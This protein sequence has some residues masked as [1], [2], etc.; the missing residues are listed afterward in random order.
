MTLKV[1]HLFSNHKVTGPAEL[2]LDTSRFI[3]RGDEDHPE[4]S[5]EG[6]FLSSAHPSDPT[7]LDD[8]AKERNSRKVTVDGLRLGKHFN[9]FRAFLDSKKLTQELKRG[10]YDLLHCHLPND[11]MIA[12]M[13]RSRLPK[14]KRPPIVRTL[15][16][17]VTPKWNW[18]QRKTLIKNTDA[19]VCFS[20]KVRDELLQEEGM[21]QIEIFKLDPPIDTDRFNNLDPEP[22]RKGR[23]TYGIDTDTFTVGIVARMQ[24]HRRFEYVL[25]AVKLAA[26]KIP[27]F[28]FVIIGRGTNQETVA[29]QPVKEMGLSDVVIFSGYISG[30]SYVETLR[31]LDAKLFVVPGSD[32]TCRA[33]REALSAGIP[34]I[35]AD[36][37]MLGE[38]VR[39]GHT[40]K[41]IEDTSENLAQAMIELAENREM[42]KSYSA[43]SRQDALDRFSYSKY[44][45]DLLSIYDRVLTHSS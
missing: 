33:V 36:R 20:S 6:Y 42:L 4:G 34:V 11:H 45:G 35:A 41:V 31:S 27:N 13:A 29:K 38:L 8:L 40:G 37:G 16:D 32:G 7:W 14:D 19:L 43:A 21:K 24:T 22:R 10:D 25:Q 28:R 18:R 26:E 17:G 3:E 23:E 5:I 30:D 9:P 1:L 2:A 39:D 12:G 15:Y 44:I